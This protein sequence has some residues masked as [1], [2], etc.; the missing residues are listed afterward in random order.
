MH[1]VR[2][3]GV[4][5]CTT[6]H[7][8]VTVEVLSD[9]E[10][11]LHD[12]VVSGLVNTRCFESEERRLE[13]SFWCTE[14]LVADGD[15]LTIGKLVGLLQ[16]RGLRGRLHLLLEV[17]S[18]VA[19]LLL[20]VSND[21]ALGSCGEWVTTLH[22]NLDEVL[23]QVTAS[24]VET[25]NGV[26]KGVTLVDGNCVGHTV[27]GVEDDTSGSAGSVQGEDGLNGDVEGGGVESLEHD[28]RH[29][30][31]VGLWVE[32][33]L[34]EQD[35]V[36]LR[37]NSE[38]VVE[39]VVPDLLHVVPVGDDTVLNGVL[40]CEDTSLGLSLVTDVRVLQRRAEKVASIRVNERVAG[41]M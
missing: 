26:R 9:V 17:E 40:E 4:H 24:Q 36:L 8:D 16:S 33:S 18:D 22:E 31:T 1:T 7:D 41:M 37:S 32:G 3:T 11:T 34:R 38:L 25:K 39:G 13:E 35:W 19:E 5:G 14:S 2:D 6:G 29:L 27:S 21:F 10:V 30:F 20:D 15:D 12:R 23:R 28:L